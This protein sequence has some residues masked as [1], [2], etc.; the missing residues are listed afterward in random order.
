[1]FFDIRQRIE[2]DLL[3][4]ETITQHAKGAGVPIAMDSNSRSTSW[5]DALTNTGGRI[6]EEFLISKQLYIMNEESDYTNF[7]SRRGT[8]N[9]YLTV[10]SDQLLRTVVNL[11]IGEQ[12]SCSDR[13]NIG[14]VIG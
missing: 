2:T 11:K 5:H 4:I 6:L 14:Y 8:R 13:S 12:E 1:M 7:R 9:I 3:K 10:I